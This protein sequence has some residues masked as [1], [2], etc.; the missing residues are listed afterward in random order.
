MEQNSI[1]IF[2]SMSL[3][4]FESCFSFF[5]FELPY[6]GVFSLI[7]PYLEFTP[8]TVAGVKLMYFYCSCESILSEKLSG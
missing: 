6:F 7:I 8:G 2:G 4:V 3:N 1:S 5:M